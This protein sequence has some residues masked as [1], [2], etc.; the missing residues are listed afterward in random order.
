MTIHVYLCTNLSCDRRRHGHEQE[1]E[2]GPAAWRRA[3]GRP[4][5]CG[6]CGAILRWLR[7]YEGED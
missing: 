5:A 1:S 4:A 2:L 3:T 6:I 7:S